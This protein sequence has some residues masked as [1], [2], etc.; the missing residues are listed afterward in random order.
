MAKSRPMMMPKLNKSVKKSGADL[1]ETCP[2][3][4]GFKNRVR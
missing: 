3:F 2:N 4:G 1:M